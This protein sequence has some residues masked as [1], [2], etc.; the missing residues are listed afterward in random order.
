M[1]NA[2]ITLAA[3]S[4]RLN[5][6]YWSERVLSQ[7]CARND[8]AHQHGAW[9]CTPVDGGARNEGAVHKGDG[10]TGRGA[11]H[12]EWDRVSGMRANAPLVRG[13]AA[14]FS[15]IVL[16]LSCGLPSPGPLCI[17]PRPVHCPILCKGGGCRDRM[18]GRRALRRGTV[19]LL[20]PFYDGREMWHWRPLGGASEQCVRLAVGCL[21]WASVCSTVNRS[22]AHGGC[23]QPMCDPE[24]CATVLGVVGGGGGDPPPLWDR[25]L[26]RI[27]PRGLAC[28][29]SL[30]RATLLRP[31]HW[32]PAT[33]HRWGGAHFLFL[34]E[35]RRESFAGAVARSLG[36]MSWRMLGNGVACAGDG[37]AHAGHILPCACGGGMGRYATRCMVWSGL[38]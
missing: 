35:G 12:R 6:A 9:G 30:K 36:G 38:A 27:G 37:R 1:S 11:V 21:G 22:L 2:F 10:C 7:I 26:T 13:A 34:A 24:G 31:Q 20:Q 14:I 17:A 28:T 5:L 29:A 16:G 8:G 23:H 32:L 15:L 18:W 4:M 33:S 19:C 3:K 25:V